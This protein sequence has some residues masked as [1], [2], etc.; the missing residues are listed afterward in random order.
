MRGGHTSS[1]SSLIKP[2][3]PWYPSP[4]NCQGPVHP[5]ISVLHSSPKPIPFIVHGVG[6]VRA[7]VALEVIPFDTPPLAQITCIT[8]RPVTAHIS[9][10]REPLLVWRGLCTFGHVSVLFQCEPKSPP[11]PFHSVVQELVSGNSWSYSVSF[12]SGQPRMCLRVLIMLFLTLLLSKLTSPSPDSFI[13]L[14]IHHPIQHVLMGHLL[15]QVLAGHP[16]YGPDRGHNLWQETCYSLML[17]PALLLT[18]CRYNS[19]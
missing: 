1:P 18:Q 13:Y 4:A 10:I 15:H 5:A 7:E 9:R 16:G 14:S 11:S 17:V 3:R 12:T 2:Q 8:S 19:S 6:L